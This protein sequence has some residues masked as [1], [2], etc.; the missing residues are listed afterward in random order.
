M[1][2]YAIILGGGR[3]ERMGRDKRALVLGG[4]SLLSLAVRA[5]GDRE[6]VVV[7]SPDLPAD[8]DD[9]RVILTLEDPPYGGPVAG[10][11]A[12]LAALA[13]AHPDDEVL[14][15]AC[16][17]PHAAAV[18]AALESS[19]MGPDGVCLLDAEAYPQYLAGR[20]R[21]SALA[22]AL[23]AAGEPRG[24]SVRRLMRGLD[25]AQRSAPAIASDVDTPDDARGAGI[26]PAG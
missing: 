25:L 17:L 19:P 15:L 2:R 11:A 23:A 10:T 13:P 18:V 8:V 26:N 12:G 4:H 14:L 21:H 9:S 22:A 24:V 6:R 20:Y 3:S 5:C 7:V 1:A 16:D